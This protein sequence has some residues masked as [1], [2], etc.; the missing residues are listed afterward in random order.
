MLTKPAPR[1]PPEGSTGGSGMEDDRVRLFS[2]HLDV[3]S[4]RFNEYSGTDTHQPP[5]RDQMILHS[6][7]DEQVC[8]SRAP[9]SALK[10][11]HHQHVGV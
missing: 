3:Y 8:I 4:V 7:G 6:S 10:P 11:E 9:K 5:L 1:E 2:G